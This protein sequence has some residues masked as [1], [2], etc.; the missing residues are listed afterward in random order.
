MATELFP[1]I[2]TADLRRSL[3]FYCDLLGGSVS[4]EFPGPDGEVVYAGVIIGTSH[5]GIGAAADTTAR[6]A[7]VLIWVYVEDCDAT[8]AQL[9]AAGVT[10]IE[11]PVDQP[12]G[13]RVALVEDPDGILVRIANRS[14]GQE[15]DT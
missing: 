10:I 6:P 2:E 1:I 14:A 4:Y 8:V 7:R 15:V 11:E 13:E 9:R 3:E 12:W 5:L